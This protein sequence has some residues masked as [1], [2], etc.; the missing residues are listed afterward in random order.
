[1]NILI[2]NCGST[3]L[4]FKLYDMPAGQVMA[5]GKIE[6][7]GVAGDAL[8]QY[9]NDRTGV[10]EEAEKQEIPGYREGISRFLACLTAPDK[11]VIR[12]VTE[13]DRVGYKATVS[14]GYLG[15][16]ELTNEVVQGMRDWLPIAPL[17]NRA[18][19]DTIAAM[20]EQLPDAVFLGCFE[21]AFH[22]NIPLCRRLY[23]VPYEWYEKY[24]LQRL[25]YHSASH[26]YIASVLTERYGPEYK[27][28]SCHLGGSSSVCAILNGGSVDTSFGMSLQTGLIHANRTGDLDIE[29]VPFLRA[30]G[31][32]EAEIDVGI[33]DKGG[34]RG[35]SGVSGDLRYIEEAIAAGNAR[36]QLAVDVFVD[37]MVRYIGGFHVE[38]GGLDT[39]VFT[40]GIGENSA[41]VRR[42]VCEKLGVLGVALNED[43][44]RQARGDADLTGAGSRVRVLVIPT[45]EEKGI[46][47]ET[48][49]F[50]R[51]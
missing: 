8:F 7:I 29:A 25:G 35:I 27:A 6:R 51:A 1:M 22:R 45:D 33:H 37:G 21:T 41:L 31:V 32:P 43:A 19:L 13:I 17:H 2:C 46:A 42:L 14:K 11:G 24:G 4:K 38:M 3:S 16:H 40:G 15:I 49:H 39:L 48:Y 5:H 20:R 23:G 18:W 47:N 34:L 12:Q 28:V 50:S 9:V 44:N 10:M 26:G 36:A 30:M